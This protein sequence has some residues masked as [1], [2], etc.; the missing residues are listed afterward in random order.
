MRRLTAFW[1]VLIFLVS[2]GAVSI[3]LNHAALAQV[4]SP[5]MSGPAS[6]DGPPPMGGS[7]MGPGMGMPQ[8]PA[9]KVAEPATAA[10][11]ALLYE[12]CSFIMRVDIRKID[13]EMLNKFVGDLVDNGI[14]AVVSRD[15]YL[16]QL[17]D[18][19]KSQL[20]QGVARLLQVGRNYLNENL[21]SKG[22]GEFF[23]LGYG[24]PK[25]KEGIN[26]CAFPSAHLTNAQKDSLITSLSETFNPLCI[27]E[28]F[29]FLIMAKQNKTE[30]SNNNEEAV[31]ELRKTVLPKIRKRFIQAAEAEKAAKSY[32]ALIQ[33]N[34]TA[35][36]LIIINLSILKDFNSSVDSEIL[37]VSQ[38]WKVADDKIVWA[39]VNVS[40]VESPKIVVLCKFAD[41]SSAKTFVDETQ[42]NMNDLRLTSSFMLKQQLTQLG[43]DVINKI[44]VD[45]FIT[46]VFEA[47]QPQIKGSEVAIPLD[48]AVFKDNAEFFVPF[49]GG[50]SSSEADRSPEADEIDWGEDNV[51]TTS[52][53]SEQPEN[54]EP[55]EN[56]SKNVSENAPLESGNANVS[57]EDSIDDEIDFGDD[58]EEIDFGDDSD[59]QPED[60]NPF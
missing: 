30:S 16:S 6:M 60:D 9:E 55:S 27:F 17:R 58:E 22:I 10:L 7:M 29:G 44:D 1:I 47:F 19:Q 51:I 12:D 34:G 25:D 4:S 37:K 15:E 5:P 54:A 26:C 13:Y 50:V 42:T 20:K 32:E 45:S 40:M 21:K 48:L 14:G 11:Q 36:S 8:Q 59:L 38:D 28:R 3:I 57:E 53:D 24:N 33:A 2:F 18:Y 52:D 23:F 49:F 31:R 35:F 56:G 41:E 43:N 46:K 39:S